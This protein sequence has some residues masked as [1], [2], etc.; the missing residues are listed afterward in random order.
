VCYLANVNQGRRRF[1]SISLRHDSAHHVGKGGGKDKKRQGRLP[2]SK[3]GKQANARVRA[4]RVRAA[5]ETQLKKARG[6]DEYSI[7]YINSTPFRSSW[8]TSSLPCDHIIPL[9][10]RLFSWYSNF[11]SDL[12]LVEMSSSR[13]L[14]LIYFIVNSDRLLEANKHRICSLS[15]R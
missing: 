14:L 11:M 8:P 13:A 15:W 10:G 3:A 1:G 9:I 2:P 6:R 4:A 12:R 7:Y 5:G